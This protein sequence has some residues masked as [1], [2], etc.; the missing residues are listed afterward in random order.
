MWR[1]VVVSVVVPAIGV[2]LMAAPSLLGFA[3]DRATDF[4]GAADS[5]R[6]VGPIIVAAG[7]LSAFR[8][9]RALR[10][11]NLVPGLWLLAAPWLLPHPGDAV[12]NGLVA[13]VAVVLLTASGRRADLS[14]YGG[15][16]KAIP[17][18]SQEG[19]VE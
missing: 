19:A 7:F 15:G 13:G 14:R 11:F 5:F 16:W 1:N 17:R 2:E 8:I 4:G 10:W 3:F 9:T 18:R 6:T 12:V